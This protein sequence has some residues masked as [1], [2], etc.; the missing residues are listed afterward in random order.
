MSKKPVATVLTALLVFTLLAACGGGSDGGATADATTHTGDHE[1][2]TAAGE[3]TGADDGAGGGGREITVEV[4]EL[5]GSGQRGRATLT[6]LA[7]GTHVL[8]ELRGRQVGPQSADIR[9]G[10]C[11]QPG[12]EPRFRLQNLSGGRGETHLQ[13]ALDELISAQYVILVQ[14]S[15]TA[16]RAHAACGYLA[17]L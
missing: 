12:P 8:V 4:V 16:A 6:E 9:P 13:V 1:E 5:N 7:G 14:R 11:E 3:T 15:T 10:S 2:T 17:A